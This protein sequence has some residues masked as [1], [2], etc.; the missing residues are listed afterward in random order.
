M[1]RQIHAS[2][3]NYDPEGVIRL[4]TDLRFCDSSR[5]YDEV[6]RWHCVLQKLTDFEQ[7]WC[8]FYQIG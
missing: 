6:S 1:W 5:A 3:I 2:T 7:R 4:A 8:N